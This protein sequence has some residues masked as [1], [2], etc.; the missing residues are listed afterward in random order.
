MSLL[1]SL[2][3]FSFIAIQLLDFSGVLV[4]HLL[5]LLDHFLL[6]GF[7][8]LLVLL[9]LLDKLL[10]KL[11]GVLAHPI[12]GVVLGRYF[13]SELAHRVLLLLQLSRDFVR[14]RPELLLFVKSG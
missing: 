8:L 4:F 5:Y 14:L 13:E 6:L 2:F 12:K 9:F 11:V 7:K 10:H 3:D 1:E